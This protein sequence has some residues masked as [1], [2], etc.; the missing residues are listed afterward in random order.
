MGDVIPKLLK[1]L[2]PTRS[3]VLSEHLRAEHRMSAAAAR[4]RLSRIKPPIYRLPV[5]LLPRGESFIY[6]KDDRNTERF[7]LSL[8]ESMR[9][10]GSIFG[11]ALDSVIAR[12]G[13]VPIDDFSVVSGAPIALKGQVASYRVAARLIEAGILAEDQHPTIGKCLCVRLAELGG[14]DM[15]GLRARRTMDAIVLDALKEWARRLGLA[16]YNSIAIR[17]DMRERR[18]GPFMWD[19]T[20]PSYLM[21][22]RHNKGKPGFFVADVVADGELSEAHVQAFIRKS[23]MLKSMLRD[24]GALPILVAERFT[25]G[26]LRAGHHAGVVLATPDNIFGGRVGAALA[27]L[28]VTLRNVA[29]AAATNPERLAQLVDDLSG[30]EGAALN[31]RGVLFNLISAHLARRDATSIDIGVIATD[32]GGMKAEIDILKVTHQAAACTL[33]ECKGKEPG[34]I[35]SVA[36]VQTWLQK[37]P[38]FRSHLRSHPHFREAVINFELWTSG[39]FAADAAE[40][41]GAEK[42]KRTKYPI[43]WK[44]GDDVLALAGAGKEKA[45]ASALREHFLRHSL[46]TV[47]GD[48]GP[49]ADK[50][51]SSK[52]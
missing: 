15:A 51:A 36:E 37:L 39:D 32:E 52:P 4:K 29:A 47:A 20:G 3:S 26:A 44:R 28:A 1:T 40:L 41:L 38:I 16:S 6:L 33:I 13:V 18:V 14:A 5:S 43:G 22:L 2:G 24:R 50:L 12:R 23:L 25:G 48:V 46:S 10:S 8:H 27:S 34:G 21:P 35:V 45:I 7:W 9:A 49:Y 17:G 30:I 42:Q 31:L 19:L 11:I